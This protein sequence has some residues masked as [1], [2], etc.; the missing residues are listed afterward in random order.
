MDTPIIHFTTVF[1]AFMA[2]M[3]P[4]ANAP[5]FIGVTDGLDQATRRSIA[6]RAVVLA[7]VIVTAFCLGGREL[8]T[9]FGITLPAFRIAG[10]VLVAL[11]GYHLL[12]G[13]PS[14][15]HVSTDEDNARSKGAVIGIAVSPLAMPLLAGPGTIATGMNFSA[16]ADMAAIIRVI[17]AFACVCLIT[18]FAFLGGESMVRVL[19]QN[20]IKV[21]S[22]LMG[23]ILS[24]VGV[25]MLIEGIK[26]AFP[27][28]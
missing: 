18:L 27:G 14:S 4:I 24:V 12:Q 11:V 16:G 10:G 22:R 9:A 7:F 19:G 23:L 15:V 21:L 2:I 20:T 5:I 17:G 26:G 6:V 25:Q 13:T 3:N 1:V 8:F 28:A